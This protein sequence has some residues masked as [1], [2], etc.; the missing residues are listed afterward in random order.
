MALCWM[1][2]EKLNNSSYKYLIEVMHCHH[3]EPEEKPETKCW[4]EYSEDSR[5]VEIRG[6]TLGWKIYEPEY[7]PGCG[8]KL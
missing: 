7:C 3:E 8:K 5:N 4:C 2:R 1:C 6:T